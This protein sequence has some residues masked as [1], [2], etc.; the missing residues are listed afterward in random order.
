MTK[1]IFEE[2]TFIWECGGFGVFFPID[3]CN[4]CL[5][6]EV[7][8]IVW[9]IVYGYCLTNCRWRRIVV[10]VKREIYDVFRAAV[11]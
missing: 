10:E 6:F 4:Y 7:I 3:V 2:C 5:C 1:R 8:K 9:T 11:R